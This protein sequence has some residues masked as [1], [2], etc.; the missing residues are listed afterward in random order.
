MLWL[1][2][3]L[4]L[5][6]GDRPGGPRARSSCVPASVNGV[7]NI[8]VLLSSVCGQAVSHRQGAQGEMLNS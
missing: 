8:C 4:V 1:L 6:A 3:M 7:L 5:C 2:R